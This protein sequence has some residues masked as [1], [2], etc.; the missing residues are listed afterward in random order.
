MNKRT[1]SS[2]FIVEI[3]KMKHQL[4]N[5]DFGEKPRSSINYIE[6]FREFD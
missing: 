6:F 2:L 4:G 1:E 5:I 3:Q